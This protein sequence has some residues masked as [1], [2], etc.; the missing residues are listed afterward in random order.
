MNTYGEKFFV[1]NTTNI[2]YDKFTRNKKE[3]IMEEI[4]RD[5]GIIARSLDGMSNI[6]FK[7]VDLTKGQYVYLV[8]ICEH[9]GI[10]PDKLAEMIKVDRTTASRAL[11][12]LEMSGFLMKKNDETNK[13][14]KKLYPTEKALQIYPFII[15]EHEHSNTVA[16]NG[17]TD[18]EIKQLSGYIQRVRD[19][20]VTDWDAVKKGHKRNY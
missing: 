20:I 5:I 1:V 3:A 14:I 13:K 9:P 15:R 11:K 12:K 16:L 8:R 2:F 6:E 4:L 17:F 10:F 7:T 18:E 19:N